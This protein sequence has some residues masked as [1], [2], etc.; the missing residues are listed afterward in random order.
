MPPTPIVEALI[1]RLGQD[2]SRRRA[3]MLDMPAGPA[4]LHAFGDE[5]MRVLPDGSALYVLG[6]AMGT[7]QLDE[8]R[9][10]GRLPC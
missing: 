2:V 1:H 10:L 8:P 4:S 6:A 5:S 9:L 7:T 3:T